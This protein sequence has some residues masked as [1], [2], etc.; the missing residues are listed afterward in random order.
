MV[1]GQV[2]KKGESPWQVLQKK[3]TYNTH[4]VCHAGNFSLLDLY[5]YSSLQSEIKVL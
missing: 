2:G 4:R 3:L 5:P 1:G